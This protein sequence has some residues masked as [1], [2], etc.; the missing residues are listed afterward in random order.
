[1]KH[2]VSPI[3]VGNDFQENREDGSEVVGGKV[4]VTN[5]N[6]EIPVVH[7]TEQQIEFLSEGNVIPS[8]DG[9]YY[10]QCFVY[11]RLGDTNLF[12]QHSLHKL[13]LAKAGISKELI[14]EMTSS[15]SY[16]ENM[17]NSILGK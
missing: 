14:E 8:V 4:N 10:F 17:K 1:M 16:K 13:D 3:R 5:F 7:L 15:L 2:Y 11:K 6:P 12:E 9:T